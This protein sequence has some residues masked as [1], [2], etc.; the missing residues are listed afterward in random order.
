M[1][2]VEEFEGV[3]ANK[4]LSVSSHHENGTIRQIYGF[5]LYEDPDR[6]RYRARGGLP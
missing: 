2:R 3:Q 4:C 6:P 5:K 1:V